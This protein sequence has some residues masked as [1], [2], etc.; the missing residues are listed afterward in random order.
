MSIEFKAV[1]NKQD[2]EVTVDYHG[3]YKK[4]FVLDYKTVE[5]MEVMP[6]MVLLELLQIDGD[7][8]VKKLKKKYDDECKAMYELINTPH[9]YAETG[10]PVE[11]NDWVLGDI[12]GD[13]CKDGAVQVL[14]KLAKCK[15]DKL[16]LWKLQ[17]FYND[18][19][20]VR[21]ENEDETPVD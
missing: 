18:P 4:L 21:K 7:E 11:F 20:K 1:Q 2:L 12:L 19:T 3:K 15:I 13:K 16:D 9:V 10:E 5:Q 17:Q 8:L 14:K 6:D